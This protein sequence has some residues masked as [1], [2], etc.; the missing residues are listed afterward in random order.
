[1]A[2]S[3]V[4][5]TAVTTINRASPAQANMVAPFTGL[6]SLSTFP[7]TRKANT[8]ITSVS[9]NGGRVR[10]MKVPYLHRQRPQFHFDYDF[11]D[12]GYIYVCYRFGLLKG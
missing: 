9:N 11:T 5:S 8:D 1:M 10:C 4:S 3:M 7:G 2:S 12:S 6:K